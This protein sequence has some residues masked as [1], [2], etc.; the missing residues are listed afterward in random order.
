MK[1]SYQKLQLPAIFSDGM[2]LQRDQ[3]IA[4]FGLAT[5]GSKVSVTLK[6]NSG[7]ADALATTQTSAAGRWRALLPERPA[8]GPYSLNV[9]DSTTELSFGDVFIGEVWLAGGQSNMEL[10][11][12]GSEDGDKAVA[13]SANPFLHF[14]EVRKTGW[15]DDDFLAEER[16]NSWQVSSPE[17][18][19]QKSAVAYYYARHLQQ[20]LGVHVGIID[21]YCGGTSIS[22]WMSKERLASTPAGQRYLDDYEKKIVGQTDEEYDRIAS[23]Y[24]KK[25]DAWNADVA[26]IKEADPT[27][28][29]ETIESQIGAC[30]WPPPAGRKSM[31]RPAGLYSTMVKRVAG[32]GLHG[33]LWYQGEEDEQRS[34]DYRTMLGCLIAEWR[35]AWN[36]SSLPFIITQ[37]PRWISKADYES[38]ADS[39]SWAILRQAQFDVAHDIKHTYLTVTIDCGEFNNIHPIDKSTVGSRLALTALAKIYG[40]SG[41]ESEGPRLHSARLQLCDGVPSINLEFTHSTE[42]AFGHWNDEADGEEKNPSERSA[43]ASGFEIAG[44]SGIFVPVSASIHGSSVILEEPSIPDPY[45]VRYA[46][47]NWGPAPLFNGQ[48]L[49]AAP[50]CIRLS[51]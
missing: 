25:F 30:P 33:V 49:P 9:T 5:P 8:G 28:S 16:R 36:S 43:Q 46:W 15:I 6:M 31:Y 22:C 14:Y 18:T 24:Q 19:A 13:A 45:F 26:R 39:G 3:Q 32:Y 42:L 4:V 48:S 29:W 38:N 2:V 11:L 37:L 44:D 23:S 20:R 50:F 34:S 12:S 27:V 21:C 35:D 7:T 40:C 47:K 1:I 17:T 10:P 51:H 41:V